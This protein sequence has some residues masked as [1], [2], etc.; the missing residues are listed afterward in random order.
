VRIPGR[1]PAL[2]EYVTACRS[3]ARAGARM[4]RDAQEIVAWWV[5]GT[6]PIAFRAVLHFRWVEPNKRRDPDNVSA[7]GRKVILDAMV[8]QGILGGDGWAHIAGLTDTF[9]VDKTDPH[10]E[11]TWERA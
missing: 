9:D 5:K 1:L 6:A 2:N 3:H 8:E 4:K 7:F 10:I 11:V